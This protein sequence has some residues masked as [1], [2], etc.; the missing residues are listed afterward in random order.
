MINSTVTGQLRE[1]LQVAM[2]GK[3]LVEK[4]CVLA[5]GKDRRFQ[6]AN[7]PISI[8][9]VIAPEMFLPI[10]IYEARLKG[11]ALLQED[12]GGTLRFDSSSLLGVT[13]H[14]PP[15]TSH[16][17]DI[18]RALFLQHV[19]LK[20]LVAQD[21]SEQVRELHPLANL[22]RQKFESLILRARMQFK[23]EEI[24]QGEVVWPVP[25]S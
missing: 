10:V 15:L 20:H 6:L 1:S 14:L 11:E 17:A 21:S 2:P 16:P 7:R 4:V 24:H 9:E 22:Y 13:A 23:A 18:V 25:I 12:L 8:R 5:M 3:D 19:T